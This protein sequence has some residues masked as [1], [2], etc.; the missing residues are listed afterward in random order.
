M[1]DT[2]DIQM[3]LEND[4]FTVITQFSGG[5]LA[6]NKITKDNFDSIVLEKKEAIEIERKFKLS[7][8]RVRRVLRSPDVRRSNGSSTWCCTPR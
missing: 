7:Q 2:Y 4:Y 6:K 5:K 3:L 8:L 1:R